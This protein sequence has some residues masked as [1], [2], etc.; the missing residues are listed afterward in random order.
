VYRLTINGCSNL[1][2]QT[3]KVTVKPTPPVPPI[4]TFS[5]NVLCSGTQFQNFGS[6]MPDPKVHNVW[7]ATGADIFS[8]SNYGQNCVVNFNN[9]GTAVITLTANVIGY[10]CPISN[11]YTVNVN[12]SVAPHP[13]VVYFNRQFICLSNDNDSYQWGYD[14]A[15]TLMSTTLTG[16]INQNYNND[17]PDFINKH[18]WVI[19]KKGDC[20]QK[21]YYNK[22]TGISNINSEAIDMKV[23]P[24][25]AKDV[26]NI[27]V[28]TV[29]GGN[30]KV[31]V[32]NLLGQKLDVQ[33]LVNNKASI[34]VAELPTG[35]YLVD[36]YRDG[37]KVTATRFVKN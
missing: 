15:A 18:Y 20:W 2:T 5:P 10:N 8:V 17:N 6:S 31:E 23:Y 4:S 35:I 28:A 16:E 13:E 22:P 9:P 37:V 26:V 34:N 19:T 36:C 32:S 30:F 33:S 3:V 21:S 29:S 7:S 24:N 1:G 27:E 12:S 25:P 14:D 11:S